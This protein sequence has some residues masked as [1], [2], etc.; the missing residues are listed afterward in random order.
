MNIINKYYM[1]ETIISLLLNQVKID[2]Y[3]QNNKAQL[4]NVLI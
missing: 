4:A 2:M 1:I 3:N